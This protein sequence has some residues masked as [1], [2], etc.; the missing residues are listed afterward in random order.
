MLAAMKQ[1]G[2]RGWIGVEYVWIDWEHCNESDNVSET[3]QLR[4]LL[5][6]TAAKL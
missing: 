1:A 5:R 4:D 6:A 3:I 2:Y